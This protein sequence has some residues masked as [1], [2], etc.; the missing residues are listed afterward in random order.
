MT[1]RPIA[2]AALAAALTAAASGAA[3]ADTIQYDFTGTYHTAWQYQ[4]VSLGYTGSFTIADPS[5][6]SVRPLQA[7]DP[8]AL[9]TAG[10]W[11]GTSLFY[12]GAG[13]LQ[14]TFANGA[15]L[16]ATSLDLV[17]NNT[18]LSDA[19]SPYP[20]GLSVQLYPRSA[21][22]FTPMT[23]GKVCP[24]GTVDDVCDDSGDDPLYRSNDAADMAS[25]RIRGL[26]FAFYAAPLP[27]PAAGVPD[28]ANS[29]GGA[30]LG[31]H[32]VNDLGQNTST[33]TQSSFTSQILAVTP[34]TPAVPEPG[35]W[36]LSLAGLAMLGALT[37]RR[38][39][40]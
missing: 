29:F 5:V 15:K 16:T 27:S 26:W 1:F 18:T 12:N 14:V 7:P 21:M 19:G 22:V 25:R 32:S 20:D 30:G 13:N 37:R 11:D 36:L 2:H 6:T 23:A 34:V 8:V 28:L 17:V 33:L 31:L 10:V 40:R 4:P 3:V 38:Q 39:P 24:D 9:R 35:A